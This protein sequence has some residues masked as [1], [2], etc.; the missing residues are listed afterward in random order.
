MPLENGLHTPTGRTCGN[1]FARLVAW[2]ARE[3]TENRFSAENNDERSDTKN[4]GHSEDR[5]FSA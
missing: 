1:A 4:R 3:R 5:T 2:M